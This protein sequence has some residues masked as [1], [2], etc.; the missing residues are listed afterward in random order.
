L[1]YHALQEDYEGLVLDVQSL[2]W[3][4]PRWDFAPIYEAIVFLYEN[5]DPEAC[6]NY[7][8]HLYSYS[9]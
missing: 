8:N 4:L 2:R 7:A 6:L 9:N 1:T 5:S 3:I